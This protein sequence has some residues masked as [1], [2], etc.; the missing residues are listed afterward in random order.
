MTGC[1]QELRTGQCEMEMG[2]RGRHSTVAF[3]CDYCGKTRRGRGEEVGQRMSDGYVEIFGV[4]CFMCAHVRDWR[5]EQAD[6][7]DAYYASL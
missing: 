7:E 4:V 3:E 1:D 6:L 5:A 2:H